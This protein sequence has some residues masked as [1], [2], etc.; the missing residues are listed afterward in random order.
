MLESEVIDYIENSSKLLREQQTVIKKLSAAN[1][2][3]TVVLI[4]KDEIIEN[5]KSNY[6]TASEKSNIILTK[7]KS[8]FIINKLY[9]AGL[10]KEANVKE[11]VEKLSSD[12]D[13]IFKT[14]DFLANKIAFSNEG[15][16]LQGAATSDLSTRN[17]EFTKTSSYSKSK[18]ELERKNEEYLRQLGCLK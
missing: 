6:K 3:Q 14:L 7:E 11:A 2:E 9:D 8:E 1:A 15:M 4:E 16:T 13:Y 10:V 12:R 5:L 17:N 18:S